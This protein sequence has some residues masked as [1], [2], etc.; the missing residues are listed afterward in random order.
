M[1]TGDRAGWA[2]RLEVRSDDGVLTLAVDGE[3]LPGVRR[4]E[5]WVESGALT[6]YSPLA[7]AEESAGAE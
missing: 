7:P 5:L 3:V 4:A 2:A 6:V 1:R